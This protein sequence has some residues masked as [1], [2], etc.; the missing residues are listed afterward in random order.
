VLVVDLLNE[1]VVVGYV[2][3][4]FAVERKF[5]LCGLLDGTCTFVFA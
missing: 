2:E 4:G 3:V 1:C 5:V